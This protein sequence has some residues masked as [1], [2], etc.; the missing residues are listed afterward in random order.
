MMIA[1][2]NGTNTSSGNVMP[3]NAVV[4]ANNIMIT[5]VTEQEARVINGVN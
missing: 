4:I 1:I 5:K 2:I 3:V